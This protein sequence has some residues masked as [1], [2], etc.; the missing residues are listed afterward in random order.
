MARTEKEKTKNKKKKPFKKRNRGFFKGLLMGIFSI[1]IAI[2]FIGFTSALIIY[3]KFNNQLP[4]VRELKNF[5][6]ST[7]TLM[8]SDQDKLIAELYLEKRIMVP[9]SKI[10]VQLKQ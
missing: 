2:L 10:P 4:D 9:L 3:L 7:V 5:E 6:P 1:S 8:Y